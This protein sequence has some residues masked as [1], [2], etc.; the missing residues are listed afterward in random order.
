[1]QP[2]SQDSQSSILFVPALSAAK[3]DAIHALAM[4]S[5]NKVQRGL[6]RRLPLSR[7]QGGHALGAALLAPAGLA[8]LPGV[9]RL[10][11]ARAAALT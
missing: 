3:R 11:R 1:M 9:L 8:L 10:A 2:A 4:G 7:C 6:H 5:E